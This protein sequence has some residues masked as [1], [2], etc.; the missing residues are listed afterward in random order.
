MRG[1][2]PSTSHPTARPRCSR[3]R[4]AQSDRCNYLIVA[5][6]RC[7]CG[8][9]RAAFCAA[10]P[11]PQHGWWNRGWG[12]SDPVRASQTR[13]GGRQQGRSRPRCPCRCRIRACGRYLVQ[14]F[15]DQDSRGAAFSRQIVCA[16]TPKKLEGL[17]VKERRSAR[18][19]WNIS[20]RVAR[21]LCTLEGLSVPAARAVYVGIFQDRERQCNPARAVA[22]TSIIGSAWARQG[23]AR[24]LAAGRGLDPLM[25]SLLLVAIA[26]ATVSFSR[27]DPAFPTP[28]WIP[29][30]Q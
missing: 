8:R 13:P 25:R 4:P 5:M 29:G 27:E 28:D 15:R 16:T 6:L 22:P 12:V 20:A 26:G 7:R 18:T 11:A 9:D 23:F 21:R 30:V 1:W 3:G 19:R 14:G 2:P 24:R 10:R 17:A